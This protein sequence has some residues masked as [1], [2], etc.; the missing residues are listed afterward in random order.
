M[1][2]VHYFKTQLF[3]LEY[4]NVLIHSNTQRTCVTGNRCSQLIIMLIRGSFARW[5]C[6]FIKSAVDQGTIYCLYDNITIYDPTNSQILRSVVVFQTSCIY[7]TLFSLILYFHMPPSSLS[8]SLG[9]AWC[10]LASLW[11]ASSSVC[12]H[13]SL[14]AVLM[15]LNLHQSG[16]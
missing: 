1:I 13:G 3:M 12:L 10:S 14:S 2:D 15:P 8:V 9:A 7:S 11:A 6:C 4:E 16:K 5:Y